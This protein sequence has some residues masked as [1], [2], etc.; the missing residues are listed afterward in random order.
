M[1]HFKF[2]S[3]KPWR[4]TKDSAKHC[5]NIDNGLILTP[6]LDKAFDKGL[7]SFSDEGQILINSNLSS[8]TLQT[9]GLHKDMKLLKK[10]NP[11]QKEYMA[12]HREYYSF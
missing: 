8:S 5:L 2:Y 4:E 3:A 12:W 9:L 1:S 11:S 10:M 7:I 6:N